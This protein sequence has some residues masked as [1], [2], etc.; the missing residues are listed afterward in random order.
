M[1]AAPEHVALPAQILGHRRGILALD[2]EADDGGF[3]PQAEA[4]GDQID[5]R[6]L[7][8]LVIHPGA[9]GH[10]VAVNLVYSLV[11]DKI[12]PRPQGQDSHRVE[13]AAFKPVGHKVGLTEFQRV[14]AG[15]SFHNGAQLRPFV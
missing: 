8:H 2:V 7:L 3:F 4:V 6:H 10:F 13:G 5:V 1:K 14:A 9:E 12:E 15:A 11:G